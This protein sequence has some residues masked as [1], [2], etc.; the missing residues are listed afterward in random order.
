MSEWEII[1]SQWKYI[2]ELETSII[3]CARK[4]PWWSNSLA[5]KVTLALAR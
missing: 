1:I 5:S 3:A 4:N 2:L